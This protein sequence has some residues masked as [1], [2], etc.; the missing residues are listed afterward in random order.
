[1]AQMVIKRVG[2]L[3][4]AKIYSLVMA[5]LGL[6][7]GLI[8]GIIF[9]LFGAAMMAR[10]G[11]VE[12]GG[13]A[14]VVGAGGTVLLGLLFMIGIPLFYGVLGFIIG[15]LGGFIYNAAS[16][17]IG[18]I[19]LEIESASASHDSPPSYGAPYN[20]PPSTFQ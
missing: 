6:I 3:S 5:V 19:E 12:S 20:A 1:M 7:F 8:Y 2:V 11:G 10:S 9:I 17:Y 4:I 13:G 14:G 18:G 16:K 15:P